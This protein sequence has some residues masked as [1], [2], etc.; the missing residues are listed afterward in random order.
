[1]NIRRFLEAQEADV[2]VLPEWRAGAPER[3][4]WAASLGMCCES[5]A[6]G[7]NRNGVFAAAKQPFCAKNK[8]P[9]EGF[10]GG[11]LLVEFASWSM[12]ACYVPGARLTNKQQIEA[13]ARYFDACTEIAGSSNR[14]PLLIVGDMNTGNQTADRAP[15]SEKYSCVKR[16]DDLSLE[17]GLVDLWRR[18][19]GA[20][21]R[22]WSWLSPGKRNPYRLDHA[23]GNAPFV[24]KFSP[25][26]W[27]DHTPREAGFTDHSAVV[28]SMSELIHTFA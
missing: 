17:N 23:F 9:V 15:D 7:K 18:E 11:L 28:I 8:T 12:L 24:E 26:C 4:C 6:I 14:R 27:Y 22:E 3:E 20:E 16:F 10:S 19:N 13:K 5:P 25:S 2:I 1:M 21:K